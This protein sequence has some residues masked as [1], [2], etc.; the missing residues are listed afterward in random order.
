[1]SRHRL[2]LIVVLLAIAA[3]LVFGLVAAAAV[4]PSG[5]PTSVGTGGAAASV[6]TLATQAAIDEL[7]AGGNAVDAAVVAAG[8]L[9]VTEPFSCGLGGG[10]FMVIRT[11]GGA[12]TTIDGR[13]KATCRSTTHASAACP[14]AFRARPRPGRRRSASTGRSRSRRRC[15]R[16]SASR[17]TATSST[18]PGTTRRTPSATGSTTF[19]RARPC[20]SIQTDCRT[21]RA[22][23]SR[24]RISPRRT[25]AS[26]ISA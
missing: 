5:P 13:E 3:A 6:E 25:S 16:A 26:R 4:A 9:G 21:S 2:R 22:Q 23:C 24:T 8:V 14:S 18:R 15:S 1:M 19:P 17:A 20:T 7:K 11:A 10:G 12:V